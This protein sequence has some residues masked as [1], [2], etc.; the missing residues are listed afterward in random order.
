MTSSIV[1]YEI[2]VASK[3]IKSQSRPLVK[4]TGGAGIDS[5]E[6]RLKRIDDLWRSLERWC[7][8]YCSSGMPI[9]GATY[10]V[11]LTKCKMLR[12]CARHTLGATGQDN[13]TAPKDGTI[14]DSDLFSLAVDIVDT[15]RQLETH[16][17][18]R[19]WGWYFRSD[20][21]WPALVYLLNEVI[22]RPASP[23]VD[24][25][26]GVV[27]LAREQYHAGLLGSRDPNR[28]RGML[29]GPMRQLT[30]KAFML[31]EAEGEQRGG[32]NRPPSSSASAGM[33]I[34]DDLSAFEA[35]WAI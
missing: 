7:G 17:D 35:F 28:A 33:G 11:M 10:Q 27:K 12:F 9:Q 18:T 29:F 15:V 8:R 22:N 20:I 26:F 25:A 2:M 32:H 23:T 24:Y 4:S 30:A 13:S 6:E 14:A 21:Q 3:Q 5:L 16:P 19:Q 31:K 34:S 1:R